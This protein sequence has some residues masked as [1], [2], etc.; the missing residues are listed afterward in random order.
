MRFGSAITFTMFVQAFSTKAGDVGRILWS[1]LQRF[2]DRGGSW[3]WGKRGGG[4]AANT[5]QCRQDDL[6]ELYTGS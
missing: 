5:R 2:Y 3:R 1:F 4:D 6:E